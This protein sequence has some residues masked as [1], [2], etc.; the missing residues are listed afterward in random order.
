MPDLGTK[1]YLGH[2]LQYLLGHLE[3][4][5][6]RTRMKREASFFRRVDWKLEVSWVVLTVKNLPA[7][8]E[9]WV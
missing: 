3:G 5:E 4:P 1:L 2:L 7:M 9:T 6:V 8:R